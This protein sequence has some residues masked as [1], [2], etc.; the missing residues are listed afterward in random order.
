MRSILADTAHVCSLDCSGVVQLQGTHGNESHIAC[1]L[2]FLLLLLLLLACFA[3]TGSIP[4]PS[5]DSAEAACLGELP[6]RG[7]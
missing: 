5:L 7:L 2:V 3:D 4:K 1:S 6:C